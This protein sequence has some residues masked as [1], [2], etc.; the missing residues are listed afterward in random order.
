MIKICIGL[1]S[2]SMSESASVP[3][4]VPIGDALEESGALRDLQRRLQR[5]RDCL[6]AVQSILPPPLAG[7][8]GLGAWDEAGWTMTVRSSAAAAKLRHWAPE[9]EGAL[10]Q[11]GLKVNAIRIKVQPARK[12]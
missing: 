6:A 12:T 10:L 3:N 11:R 2:G 9:I 4:L 5:S 8:I 1:H 7:E